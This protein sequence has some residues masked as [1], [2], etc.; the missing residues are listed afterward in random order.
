MLVSGLQAGPCKR[1][2][3]MHAINTVHRN[4]PGLGPVAQCT[5]REGVLAIAVQVV[6][7]LFHILLQFRGVG[8]LHPDRFPGMGARCRCGRGRRLVNVVTV[9]QIPLRTGSLCDAR[10]KGGTHN[11][12]YDC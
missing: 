12:F 10:M 7:L 1:E 4:G 6:C 3:S 11:Q 5:R 8:I 9:K 2:D